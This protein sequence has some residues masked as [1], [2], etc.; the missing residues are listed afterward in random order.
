M[1]IS[2]LRSLI[3]PPSSSALRESHRRGHVPITLP[4]ED[5]SLKIIPV[6][7]RMWNKKEVQGSE[8]YAAQIGR[9]RKV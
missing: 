3:L 2:G 5:R 7:S 6:P 1:A 4:L 9:Y 8:W